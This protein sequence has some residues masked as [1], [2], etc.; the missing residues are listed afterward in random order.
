M[1]KRDLIK[2]IIL[3]IS[4]GFVS[5]LF[6]T[7]GG[8][9]LVPAFIYLLKMEDKKSRGTSLVCILVM[10][11]TSGFFYYRNDYIDWNTGIL[12]AVGGIVGGFLGAKFLKKVSE[13][14]LKIMFLS[15]LIYVSYKMITS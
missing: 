9:I 2:K 7:G 5:G 15:F 12:C 3:G 13:K 4:A 11:V 6:A 8:M 14:I 1:I 10:V